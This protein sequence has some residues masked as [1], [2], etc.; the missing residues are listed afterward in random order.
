MIFKRGVKA[1]VCLIKESDMKLVKATLELGNF[2]VALHS[3]ASPPARVGASKYQWYHRLGSRSPFHELSWL[4]VQLNHDP[5]AGAPSPSRTSPSTILRCLNRV[6]LSFLT[7][8]ILSVDFLTSTWSFLLN[9]IRAAGGR[10]DR[11]NHRRRRQDG[12]RRCRV[13][14]PP[15]DH[16]AS[17]AR[18]MAHPR[19]VK[20]A[21]NFAHTS[22]QM[23]VT[24]IL[25]ASLEW[26]AR[27]SAALLGGSSGQ[28][29]HPS[30]NS[31]RTYLTSRNY[32]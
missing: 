16:Y 26:A 6:A 14:L 21:S 17:G 15:R 27:T 4:S 23:Y 28:W 2:V 29:H 19:H 10:G 11:N 24:A 5:S 9:M 8:W 30:S 1:E 25:S 31:Q 12:P 7:S 22:D 13:R 18:Y 3:E 20:S 32:L